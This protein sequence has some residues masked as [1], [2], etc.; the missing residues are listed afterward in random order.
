MKWNY[1]PIA[2]ELL[3]TVDKVLNNQIQNRKQL[4]QNLHSFFEYENEQIIIVLQLIGMYKSAYPLGLQLA[5][6]CELLYTNMKYDLFQSKQ[7][8]YSTI[9]RMSSTGLLEL[10]PD[11]S[12]EITSLGQDY[13]ME[14]F[15]H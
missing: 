8:I 5:T 12:F 14:E 7:Y 11:G 3:T 13:V 15:K 6:L 2:A 10:H 4:L 9:N 1:I